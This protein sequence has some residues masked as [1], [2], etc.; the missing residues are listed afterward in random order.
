MRSAA[1][2]FRE[3]R[4]LWSVLLILIHLLLMKNHLF[5]RWLSISPAS[6]RP[7]GVFDIVGSLLSSFVFEW[8]RRACWMAL[9]LVWRWHRRIIYF[10][11][12]MLTCCWLPI[13]YVVLC[14][15]IYLFR[16]NSRNMVRTKL[17]IHVNNMSERH[18][19]WSF[20]K[21]C[22]SSMMAYCARMRMSRL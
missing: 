6:V 16:S 7:V 1:I 11:A 9:V 20:D 14:H 5:W 4:L 2:Q 18:A 17:A 10:L 19:G 21:N 8:V 13:L 22:F 3:G 12:A 15:F